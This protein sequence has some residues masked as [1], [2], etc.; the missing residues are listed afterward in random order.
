M[1]N[2]F[3]LLAKIV[4]KEAALK[5]FDYYA[6]ADYCWV[7]YAIENGRYDLDK[8]NELLSKM[9]YRYSTIRGKRK[10]IDKFGEGTAQ[11]VC[12]AIQQYVN[13]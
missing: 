12:D 7:D 11:Y 3:V 2:I 8:E 9:G 10:N 5:R 1:P 13:L 6:K 4:G